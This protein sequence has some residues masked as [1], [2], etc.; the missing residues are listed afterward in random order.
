MSEKML[1]RIFE[2]MQNQY[3]RC[4]MASM[5]ISEDQFI[6][7][8]LY[9]IKRD[10]KN[11]GKYITKSRALQM[12][13][14]LADQLNYNEISRGWYKHGY[15]SF[16]LDKVLNNIGIRHTLLTTSINQEFVNKEFYKLLSKPIKDLESKFI[17]PNNEFYDWI[18]FEIAPDHY[19]DFYKYGITFLNQLSRLKERRNVKVHIG[20]HHE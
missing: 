15:Y 11:K 3:R 6:H 8:V 7:T 2:L 18:H 5:D 17:L 4:K 19:K 13:C 16:S 20:I 9:T 1:S 14:M 10:F 12:I